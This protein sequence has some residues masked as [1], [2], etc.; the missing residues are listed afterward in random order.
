[1]NKYFLYYFFTAILYATGVRAQDAPSWG[2][3][4]TSISLYSGYASQDFRWSI[5][6]NYQGQNPNIYSE[7][8]WKDLHAAVAGATSAFTIHK[9]WSATVEAGSSFTFSGQVTD[10]D[11]TGDNRTGRSYFGLFNSNKGISYWAGLK[12][13]YSLVHKKN[14]HLLVFAGYGYQFQNLRILENAKDSSIIASGLNSSYR[15]RMHGPLLGFKLGYQLAP[16]L[17]LSFVPEYGWLNYSGRA[18][19]NLV[20]N[21][22]HPLSFEHRASGFEWKGRL[23]LSYKFDKDISA[24]VGFDHRRLEINGGDDLLYL[25]DGQVLRSHFNGAMGRCSTALLGLTVFIHCKRK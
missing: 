11:Y 6:G 8:T 19:W 17:A 24:F 13:F 23:Q 9:R 12:P 22:K 4:G 2:K 3:Q 1:M 14:F 20:S 21:F 25:S 10:A 7:L 18:D 15:T 16:R 5:A